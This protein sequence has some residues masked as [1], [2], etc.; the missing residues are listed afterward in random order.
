MTRLFNA[1]LRSAVSNL[2]GL[3]VDLTEKYHRVFS[4]WIPIRPRMLIK[5][6]P[7]GV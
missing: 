2:Q 4:I 7:L 1:A 3:L 5:G 6:T